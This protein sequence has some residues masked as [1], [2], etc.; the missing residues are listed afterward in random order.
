M[1]ED[2][3]LVLVIAW[4]GLSAAVGALAAQWDRSGGTWFGLSLL[5][6]PLLMFI[7]LVVQ[8]KKKPA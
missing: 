4:V 7:V 3:L 6:S 1:T 8:G 5:F 2:E